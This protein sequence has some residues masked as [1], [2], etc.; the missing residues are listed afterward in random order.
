M[1][2]ADNSDPVAAWTLH[3]R[4]V[5]VPFD[6]SAHAEAALEVVPEPG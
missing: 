6:F 3:K 1:S 5:V 4:K 2:A